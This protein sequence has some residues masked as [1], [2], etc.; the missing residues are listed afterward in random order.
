MAYIPRDVF[1]L[2]PSRHEDEDGISEPHSA[3]LR[4]GFLI[5][6]VLVPCGSLMLA[7]LAFMISEGRPL[8][9]ILF[10]LL[11][12]TIH[13]TPFYWLWRNAHRKA[14]EKAQAGTKG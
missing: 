4:N 2:A 14:R 9:Q 1:N 3:W 13:T 10:A 5:A 8:K 11:L 12:A 7:V 6:A